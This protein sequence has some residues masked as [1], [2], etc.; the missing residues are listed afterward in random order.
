MDYIIYPLLSPCSK[1]S[2]RRFKARK[3][4]RHTY[5]P[6][7]ILIERLK[8]QTG[9]SQEEIFRQI[10]KERHFMEKYKKYF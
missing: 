5:T 3:G 2:F 4:K 10:E 9:M 8:E 6:R 1:T 7:R